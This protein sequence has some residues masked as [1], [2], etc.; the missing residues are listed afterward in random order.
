MFTRVLI[1]HDF[2][3]DADY[4]IRC[5]QNIPRIR[6]VILVHITRSMYLLP[7]PDREN[8]ETDYAR[9]RLEKVKNAIMLPRSKVRIIVEEITGGEVSEAVIRI[10]EREQASLILMGRRGRGVIETVLLGST[11]WDILKYGNTDL[12]LIHPPDKAWN[13]SPS[14]PRCPDLFTNVMI[15]TD[16]SEPPIETLIS[17]IL[18]GAT[19]AVLFHAVSKGDSDE[20]VSR[21]VEQAE[22]NMIRIADRYRDMSL[23]VMT[24]IRIGDPADEIIRVSSGEDVSL[25]VMKSTGSRGILNKFIGGTT[26]AVGRSVKKPLLILKKRDEKSHE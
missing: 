13:S 25:V 26:E 17:D 4:V 6:E 10:A 11:A 20:E 14:H 12:L 22:E 3:D 8:P 23:L 15:C 9:L 2:S 7:S 1:P 21:A 19:G 24:R 5:L 16:F 18:P